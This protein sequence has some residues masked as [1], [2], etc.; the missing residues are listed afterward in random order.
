MR[1]GGH[2]EEKL[3]RQNGRPCSHSRCEE[4]ANGHVSGEA[5]GHS[6]GWQGTSDGKGVTPE[7]ETSLV[8][9]Q[10]LGIITTGTQNIKSPP[11]SSSFRDR[12]GQ[13]RNAQPRV[14]PHPLDPPSRT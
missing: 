10:A 6:Q 11:S 4:E 9:E 2:G 14:G 3:G 8:R 5:A 13:G 1:A 12:L 7:T